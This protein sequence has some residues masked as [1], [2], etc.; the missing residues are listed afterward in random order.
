M[1]WIFCARV[2]FS[3]VCIRNNVTILFSFFFANF[4]YKKLLTAISYLR[5]HGGVIIRNDDGEHELLTEMSKVNASFDLFVISPFYLTLMRLFSK[6][7]NFSMHRLKSF[8][9]R[10]IFFLKLHI[11]E[12]VNLCPARWTP[13]YDVFAKITT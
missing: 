6:T 13:Y 10:T 9:F 8:D 1:Q 7:K 3:S 2:F 12:N 4:K 11:S 5:N